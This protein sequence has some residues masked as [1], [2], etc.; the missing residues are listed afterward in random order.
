MNVFSPRGVSILLFSAAGIA[1]AQTI[2][3]TIT[4]T[5]RDPGGLAI[6]GGEIKLVQQGTAAVR[7]SLTGDRG[8]FVIGS[9]EPGSY[10]LFVSA[11]GFKRYEMKSVM[12]SA[13]EIQAVPEI[14]LEIGAVADQ[15]TVEARAVT[16]QTA[17]GERGGIITSD[18]VESVQ[19]KNR[20]VMEM[21]QLLPGVVDTNTSE[22]PSRNW[23]LF[24]QGTRQNANNVSEDGVTINAIGNNFN[25]VVGV[26][27]DAI[28]E[29]K[30]LMSTLQAEYGRVAGA[31][32][33]LIT[34]SG[35]Q[36]FHGLGSYF[37]RNEAFN[38]NNFFSNRVGLPRSLYRY[39]T[40]SGNV[41][42]PVFIPG[43]F[44]RNR[45]KLFFFFSAEYWPI[46]VPQPLGQ[47][48]VPSAL[49]RAGD[50]SQSVDL[51]GKLI[52][53]VDPTTGQ[54]FAGNKIPTSRIDPNGKALLN[55]FPL[56]NFTNRAI[57]GGAYNYVF[58]ASDDSP[59]RSDTLKLD[60]NANP[61]NRL[62]VNR[63]GTVD[64]NS[65]ALG[66]PDSG[67]TNWPQ[68]SKTYSTS[69]ELIVGHYTRVFSPTL[70]DELNVG[71]STR[72]AHDTYSDSE[73]QRN[74]RDTVGYT[75]GQFNPAIN[76]LNLIPN[77]TFGGVPGAPANLLIE[78]R[79]PLLATQKSTTITDNIT[80]VLAVHTLKAG[81]YFDHFWTTAIPTQNFNGSFDFGRNTNNPLDTGYAYANAMAGVFNSYTEPTGRPHNAASQGNIEWFAQ[82]N[83]KLSRRLTV[84]YG[85]RFYLLRPAT[86][87]SDNW[88]GFVPSQ[89]LPI[90]QVQLVAPAMVAG[91]R[92]GLDP[93]SGQVY[94]STLIGVI[95]P[96]SL[97]V[98]NGIVSDQNHPASP[99]VK[100]RGVL[101]APRFGFAYDVTGDG[102]TA[103][104]GGFGV[105]YA[106]N[107]NTLVP[108]TRN[109]VINFGTLAALL[110][111]SGLASPQNV[112]GADPSGFSSN[113][114]NFSLSVQRNIGW[115][116]VVDAG[117]VGSLGRHLDWVQNLNS[118]PFGADFA[119][120]NA[121]PTNPKVPLPTAFLRPYIGY[122]NINFTEPASSSNYH[123]LQVG[124]NR[125]FARGLQF[126]ASWTWSKAMDFNDADA[127]AVSSLISPHVWN[128]G[129][130]SFDRTHIVKI[131][132]LW[133][134][135]SSPFKT[136]VARLVLNGWMLNGIASFI[137]GAPLGIG[138]A[139]TTSTDI[140]GSPT[141]GA[142]IVVLSNPVLPKD[143]R[144]FS[145]N[146][147]TDVFALPAKGT[148]GDAATTL[149]RGP[150]VNNWDVSL[151]KNFPVRGDK[152]RLQFRWEMYNAFN[153]TQFSALDTTA[154]FDASGNQVNATFG[155]FT[156]ARPPRV[157]QFALRFYF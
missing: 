100:N 6:A 148:I 81:F 89:F 107:P 25:S 93:I 52:P 42:G 15:V 37:V 10:D 62:F 128:Y 70:I 92:V 1:A 54:P 40:V 133:D 157:M 39:N 94:P 53:I 117:Y 55:V 87:S 46:K 38:A 125:R 88:A 108:Y 49:E 103:V 82:D 120:Q 41:G 8:N 134:I 141:D 45:D 71:G 145:K 119:P 136:P 140:T 79:F 86:D 2:T 66:I 43:K 138:Y 144:T 154:R 85:L 90:Q 121:D 102:K 69:G 113:V 112:V 114:M 60:Y 63:T 17:S 24:V 152:M 84:E 151:F 64:T 14:V 110:S 98:D 101:Y 58:Q 21:L 95:A 68:M 72:P 155:A 73:V 76:P 139:T 27:M 97:H 131:N 3:G 74:R 106:Q 142:R 20:T 57:S 96:E 129:M 149:I 109:P 35:T 137:S 5:V 50:F 44:N 143:Q 111:S 126:G 22:A 80:K 47:V 28:Q 115:E 116:T 12:L 9:L 18:Q 48:T 122:G 132:W 31:N 36:N 105:F 7:Q 123:S 146:F 130:A 4:G 65:G 26:G 33:Q 104:R 78:G 16:V 83:W 91:K 99:L 19:I 67:T 51:N 59:L 118:I 75:L 30:V 23:F 61:S 13:S 32:V 34:K 127:T 135:P 150:G 11:S 153:H 156:A 56:P 147:R 77:A 124:V 29:V